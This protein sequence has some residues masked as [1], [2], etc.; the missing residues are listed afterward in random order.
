MRPVIITQMETSGRHE[1]CTTLHKIDIG[2]DGYLTSISSFKFIFPNTERDQL[3]QTK[4]RTI[5]LRT[6]NLTSIF[7]LGFCKVQ[8]KYKRKEL[9]LQFFAVPGCGLAL[10]G[11]PYIEH[12]QHTN[13]HIQYNKCIKEIQRDECTKAKREMQYKQKPMS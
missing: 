2:S 9:S 5:V 3:N 10:L 11:L 1:G 7:Q 12:F 6:G 13:H 4:H 8:S